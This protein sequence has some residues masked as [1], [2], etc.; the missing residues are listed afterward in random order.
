M[1]MATA[2]AAAPCRRWWSPMK[3]VASAASLCA[4]LAVMRR[5]CSNSIGMVYRLRLALTLYQSS[6]ACR[7]DADAVIIARLWQAHPC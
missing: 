3:R 5:I 4:S 7:P 1:S 2:Q 6:G